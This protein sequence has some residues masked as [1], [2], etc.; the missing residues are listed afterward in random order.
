MNY[1]TT[2]WTDF[3]IA[4]NCCADA[5]KETAQRC[6][7]EWKTNIE[8]LTEFIMVLNHKSWYWNEKNDEYMELYSNLYH[9]YDNLAIKY[10]QKNMRKEDL[11]YY[12]QTL[13]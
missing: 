13:D 3:T 2:F 8:Y 9:K 10:I 4:E 5:I 12:F 7:N 11:N 1:K 6:F